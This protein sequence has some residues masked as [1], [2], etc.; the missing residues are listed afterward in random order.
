MQCSILGYK[1]AGMCFGSGNRHHMSVMFHV[2][3]VVISLSMAEPK[4]VM[5]NGNWENRGIG[6]WEWSRVK[7]NG[8]EWSGIIIIIKEKCDIIA[9]Y[10]ELGIE[11]HFSTAYH[12]QTQGQVKNNNK[13]METYLCMCCSH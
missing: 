6:S 2:W 9:I 4:S 13:W 10:K 7:W 12:P 8:V 5:C 1:P 11:L 3:N